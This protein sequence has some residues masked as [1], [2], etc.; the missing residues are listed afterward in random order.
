MFIKMLLS[1]RCLMFK[2]FLPAC[3]SS[4]WLRMSQGLEPP[5]KAMWIVFSMYVRMGDY[6]H[7]LLAWSAAFLSSL[8]L[9]CSKCLING[10]KI[11]VYVPGT[12]AFL[13]SLTFCSFFSPVVA[14]VIQSCIK[15]WY[16]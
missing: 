5:W 10:R 8:Y 16:S 7:F 15:T 13:S 14:E 4:F 2:M 11:A 9:A 1:P 6:R 3:L 12:Q